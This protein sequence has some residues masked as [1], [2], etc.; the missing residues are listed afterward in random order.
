M[1]FKDLAIKYQ[2]LSEVHNR[3]KPAVAEAIKSQILT[4]FSAG[5]DPYGNSWAELKSGG[6]SH[7]EQSGSLKLS[8]KVNIQFYGIDIDLSYIGIF[9]HKGWTR[10]GKGRTRRQRRAAGTVQV[11]RPILSSGQMPPKWA[12]IIEDNYAKTVSEICQG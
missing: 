7:L 6:Q 10:Q 3:M 2:K 11:A 1:S 5:Q 4:Q 12:Q 8:L 9:H